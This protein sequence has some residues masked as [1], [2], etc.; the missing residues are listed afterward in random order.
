M[1]IAIALFGWVWLI[2]IMI[3]VIKKDLKQKPARDFLKK[4][5][6]EEFKDPIT[7]RVF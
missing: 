7:R 1:C 4:L 3:Y 2:I 5:D 6:M